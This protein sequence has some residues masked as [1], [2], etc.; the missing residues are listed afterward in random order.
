MLNISISGF[1]RVYWY[2]LIWL[3]IG[4]LVAQVLDIEAQVSQL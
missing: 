3:K 2:T 4:R 1:S